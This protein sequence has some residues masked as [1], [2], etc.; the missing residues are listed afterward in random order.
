MAGAA[1][2]LSAVLLPV[3]TYAGKFGNPF[4]RSTQVEQLA[5]EIDTLERHIDEFGSVVA[6]QPDVWGES[7]LTKHRREVEEQLAK[8]LCDFSVT[9][10]AAIS[11]SDQAFLAS[12]T[13]LSA[14]VSGSTAVA[15]QPQATESSTVTRIEP[16]AVGAPAG[17]VSGLD[18]ITRNG[19]QPAG[20][21]G[22]GEKGVALEPT[23]MLDQMKRYLDHLNEIRR[24]NE[25]DDNADSPG[26]SLNL[27]RIPVSIFPGEKTRAGY[28]AEITMTITPEFGESFLR[29]TYRDLVIND[30][31]DQ[32]A[33]PLFIALNDADTVGVLTNLWQDAS[34]EILRKRRQ[35]I[36]DTGSDDC[37]EI[38][39]GEEIAAVVKN[40]SEED[41][42]K[43]D[44]LF[45]ITRGG[46]SGRRA[47]LA[48]A[49]TFVEDVFERQLA[50]LTQV[51]LD[52]QKQVQPIDGNQYAFADVQRFL[53]AELQAA[54]D[55]LNT[56]A[57]VEAAKVAPEYGPDLWGHCHGLATLV[58]QKRKF[59]EDDEQFRFLRDQEP[60]AMS[61]DHLDK[62]RR[63]FFCAVEQFYPR[64]TNTTTAA[65]SWAIVVESA[66]LNLELNDDIRRV[67][68]QSECIIP[69]APGDVQHVFYCPVHTDEARLAFEQYVRCRWPMHVFAVDPVTQDQNV[70]DSFSRRR[71]MQLALS[72]ALASGKINAN[73]FSRFARR[74]ELDMETIALN[75]TAVGFSH[76]SDTFGWRFYPRVQSP[77]IP[78]HAKVVMRDLFIGG[79][80]RDTDMKQWRIEPGMR[81]CVAIVIM[82]SFLS[83]ARIDVRG[84]W[85]SLKNPKKRQL[86]TSDA[87]ELSESIQSMHMLLS[88]CVEDAHRYRDGEVGRLEQAVHQLDARLPLQTAHLQ[89]PYENTLGGFELFDRGV[90]HLGPELLGYFGSPGIRVGVDGCQTTVFLVGDNFSV[91][92]TQVIAGNKD[93]TKCAQLL[94]R[95]VMK[96]SIPPDVHTIANDTCH[97]GGVDVRVATPYGV[98]GHL[99]IPV[100]H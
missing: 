8:K 55:F 49:P 61:Q 74:I 90:T 29:D 57:T 23:V 21:L 35:A 86:D 96:V 39:V 98:S 68:C 3:E 54:Y 27:V 16:P 62:A 2:A 87:V 66:L 5:E 83:D 19:P 33:T 52:A 69:D 17:Q 84:N 94:S 63:R 30:V 9:L 10:N 42:R 73:H 60:E 11:R 78:S 20:H 15:T 71:E 37:I 95:Q 22:F 38:R 89:I 47:K 91:H 80:S 100:M 24:V 25:G 43:I 79:P 51:A 77:D 36:V 34:R 81:E 64:A 40:L 92:D 65:L 88:A 50:V 53:M 12:A 59:I 76:G 44:S 97:T 4:R 56:P 7:R 67:Q 70:A 41:R 46:T 58:R 45:R 13:S 14:A 85:F 72:L 48:V 28:G 93:V 99:C 1:V 6:K 75:R 32:L 82:P 18:V 26:Y 31:V